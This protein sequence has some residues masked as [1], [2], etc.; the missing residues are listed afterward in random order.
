[1]L[2]LTLGTYGR[3]KAPTRV[4]SVLLISSFIV[5]ALSQYFCNCNDELKMIEATTTMSIQEIE[6]RITNCRHGGPSRD[7]QGTIWFLACSMFAT[8]NLDIDGFTI[9][10]SAA[11]FADQIQAALLSS[12]QYLNY[13]DIFHFC[14]SG[15]NDSSRFLAALAVEAW[16]ERD[17]VSVK[18]LLVRSILIKHIKENGA[19]NVFDELMSGNCPLL[20]NIGEVLCSTGQGLGAILGECIGN[21]CSCPALSLMLHEQQTL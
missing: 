21:S 20:E 19:A 4:S 12:L 7:Q 15:G 8:S 2:A 1:M 14:L 3:A 18:K 5:I 16:H 11:G 6:H 10:H 17:A 9:L 13:Q